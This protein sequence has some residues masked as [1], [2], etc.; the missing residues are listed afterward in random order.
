MPLLLLVPVLIVECLMSGVES[1]RVGFRKRQDTSP[2]LS[3]SHIVKCTRTSVYISVIFV[4]ET[5]KRRRLLFDT[6]CI[7]LLLC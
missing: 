4:L 3:P 1:S 6:C 7:V 5:G 2:F